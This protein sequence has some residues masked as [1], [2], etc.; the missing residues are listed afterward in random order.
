M[1]GPGNTS[2]SSDN[3]R[4]SNRSSS[5]NNNN[6]EEEDEEATLR[7]M[8][9]RLDAQ[10]QA[11]DITRYVR[12]IDREH[13]RGGEVEEEESGSFDVSN[14]E[15]EGDGEEYSHHHNNNE[16]YID[17][18]NVGSMSNASAG[19][20]IGATTATRGN[21]MGLQGQHEAVFDY[22]DSAGGD[23]RHYTETDNDLAIS[24]VYGQDFDSTPT[25]R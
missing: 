24:F 10:S 6:T 13:G 17:S 15:E 9:D 8:L 2:N 22:N 1:E 25:A 3:N 18:N 16:A 20:P 4:S 5:M 21:F 12:E 11:R 7:A 14:G 19:V 23:D